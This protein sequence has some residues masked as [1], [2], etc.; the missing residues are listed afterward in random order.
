MGPSSSGVAWLAARETAFRA[1]RAVAAPGG[2]QAQGR[3]QL[4][5]GR[6]LLAL[7]GGGGALRYWGGWVGLVED[8]PVAREALLRR[9]VGAAAYP[10]HR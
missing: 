9:P 3:P 8:R 4:G 5:P 2:E 10:G 1:G 7:S 6:S